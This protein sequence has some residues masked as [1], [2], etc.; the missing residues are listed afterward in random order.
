MA[1][2]KKKRL[3]KGLDALLTTRDVDAGSA[4]DDSS[5]RVLQL[6]PR[7][8]TPNPR[9]PRLQFDEDSLEELSASI[10][11][12][13]IQEPVLVRRK[14]GSY[15]LVSGERRVR[16][17][18]LADCETI[19]AICKDVS[20]RDMLKLGLVEN[21]HREDLNPIELAKAY[22]TLIDEFG[23][24]QEELARELGKRRVTVTNTLRLLNLPEDVRDLV[25][26]GEL[27]M[28]HAKALLALGSAR[29]QSAA[30]RKV[31]AK[32]LSVRETERMATPKRTKSK[33]PAA[34][35]PYVAEIED[36]LRKRLG[37]RVTVRTKSAQR[38]RIEIEYFN[39]DELD[40]ILDI[41]RD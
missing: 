29:A 18:V 2:A 21:I 28:G 4:G 12:D 27:S 33:T 25:A 3:G 38:G 1:S 35:N 10:S 11:R 17:A 6:D 7:S 36:D 9:Q 26:K 16:A 19:P 14:G 23:W 15:E 8:I 41:L 20:D 39:L 37:T 31:V 22:Q 24:T 32:G 5:A 34:K 13:G 30:A 40:R